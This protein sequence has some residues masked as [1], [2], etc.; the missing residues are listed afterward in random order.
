MAWTDF[1]LPSGAMT[2]DEQQANYQ[3]LQQLSNERLR[4]RQQAGGPIVTDLSGVE[5]LTPSSDGV[6]NAFGEGLKEGLDNV[7]ST[8]KSTLAGTVNAVFAS[9][10][11]QIWVIGAIGL[12]IYAGGG[13]WLQN[14]L[15]KMKK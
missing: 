2:D 10:P 6:I 3:R 11:W 12:F 4:A 5:P 14:R 7:T 9:I 8:T 13:I 1:F 15:A